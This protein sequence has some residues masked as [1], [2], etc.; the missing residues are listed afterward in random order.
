LTEPHRMFLEASSRELDT[1]EP[2]SDT[3]VDP[4]TT[5]TYG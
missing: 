2:L 1:D 3:R 4:I 5:R